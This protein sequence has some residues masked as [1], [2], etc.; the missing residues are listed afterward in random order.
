MQSN[1]WSIFIVSPGPKGNKRVRIPGIVLVLFLFLMTLGGLGFAR[2]AFFLFSYGSA[3]FGVYNAQ[4][5]NQHLMMKVRFLQKLTEKWENEIKEMIAYEDNARLRYGMNTISEDVRRAGIGGLPTSE[6]MLLAS[7]E[8]P[9]VHK[10]SYIKE[11][12]GALLRKAD[13]QDSTFS[14][15]ASHVKRQH[16]RLA[17]LPSTW[18]VRGRITSGYGY[19][20]HPFLKRSLFHEGLDIAN[21]EW[22][23]VFA[24]ADGLVDFVGRKHDFGNVVMMDHYGGIE[25]VYAHLRQSAVAEGQFVKRGEP[26]G[27][28]GNTGRSTGPHLHYEIRKMGRHVNPKNYILPDDIIVE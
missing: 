5:E 17:Q 23:P 19:R 1:S 15:M 14:R 13:L 7:L 8:D 6:E 22:T 18:P 24:P 2:C 3:K 10:V 9:V 11:H 16:D 20:F 12:I 28:V 25:T 4:R 27:Y 21:K 26:I